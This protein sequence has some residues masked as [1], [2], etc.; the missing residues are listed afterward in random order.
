[1][2]PNGNNKLVA[3]LVALNSQDETLVVV[4]V[5]L[6]NR[7]Y[8][9]TFKYP[10]EV[11]PALQKWLRERFSDIGFLLWQINRQRENTD[12]LVGPEPTQQNLP[13]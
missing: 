6:E 4:E 9:Y 12:A 2:E 7:T 8:D 11:S 10:R 3:N 13:W 1:M 5:W